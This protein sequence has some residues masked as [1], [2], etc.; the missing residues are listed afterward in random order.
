MRQTHLTLSLLL[1][2][3]GACGGGSNSN[4]PDAPVDSPSTPG[5]VTITGTAVERTVSG[6]TDVGMA[7]IGAYQN[8]NDTTPVATTM[9][10]AD[11]TFTLMISTSAGPLDG[12]LKATKTGLKDTYLYAPAPIAADTTAPVNMINPNTLGLLVAVALQG[13][14][15]D[16]NKGLIA[17]VVVDGASATSTP[18]AG[19][20]AS[21]NPAPSAVKYTAPGG[22][23]DPGATVTGTDGTAF[24]FNVT[25]NAP[26]TVS[27]TKSGSTFKSHVIKAWP[28][29]LTTTIVT[30]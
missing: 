7:T 30:P 19:A 13:G 27:A 16:V 23:P 10:A 6:T 8:G 5:M 21:S 12:Y 28:N 24:L 14:S 25:P 22:L 26:V 29:A 2:L 15:Q 17:L 1:V 4:T 3:V 11:G 18:V 20:M 9:T